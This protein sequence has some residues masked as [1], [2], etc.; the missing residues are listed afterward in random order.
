MII[1]K[2]KEN[3]EILNQSK[4]QNTNLIF[5]IVKKRTGTETLK[6]I[7]VSTSGL[8][9]SGFSYVMLD[10]IFFLIQVFLLAIIF[11]LFKTISIEVRRNENGSS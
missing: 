5:V 4:L 8:N 7:K 2:S 9:S 11:S 3:R 6:I 10:L 1:K